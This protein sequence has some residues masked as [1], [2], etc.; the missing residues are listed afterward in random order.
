M[1][2][3]SQPAPWHP[4]SRSWAK[5]RRCFGPRHRRS[6]ASPP[7]ALWQENATKMR[8]ILAQVTVSMRIGSSHV[9]QTSTP[10][11]ASL[12]SWTA[13]AP[14][15]VGPSSRESASPLAPSVVKPLQHGLGVGWHT[16]CAAASSWTRPS[17]RPLFHG[18]CFSSS[19][20]GGGGRGVRAS[21]R[22]SGLEILLCN[23]DFSMAHERGCCRSRHR[24]ERP[25]GTELV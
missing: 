3:P 16:V 2:S 23:T 22:W 1:S 20:P 15:F 13:R 17:N 21:E 25:L 11:T 9:I 12:A 14:K 10:A 19:H 5:A 6:P 24:W 18:T 7:T 8:L 4:Q